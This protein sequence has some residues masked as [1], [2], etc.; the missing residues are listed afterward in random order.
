MSI[1][2]WSKKKPDLKSVL[3]T[4][5]IYIVFVILVSLL[6]IM[7]NGTFVSRANIVNVLRQISINGIIAIGMTFVIITGGIDLSVGAV[8]ALAG[9][10][11]SD[12]AHTDPKI[13]LIIPFLIAIGVGA[14]CGLNSGLIVSYVG[15]P[16]FVVTMGMMSIARGLTFLYTGGAPIKKLSDKF[17]AIGKGYYIGI[18]IP[19]YI[20]AIVLFIAATLLHKS[21][22]GRSLYAIG[23][24]EEAAYTSGIS[25]KS[26][27]TI[28]YIISGICAAI[29]GLI[30]AARTGA[31]AALAGDGYELNAIAAVVIGGTS[32]SGGKGTIM[33]TL[34]GALIIGSLSNGLDLM[35]V[36]SYIQTVVKG[37]III[38]AVCLDARA[39]SNAKR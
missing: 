34:I 16:P 39:M 3:R 20:L 31:A 10:I 24:N 2:G 28:A 38:A 26:Q 25:V 33:G 11:G 29:C 9:A 23:G 6:A 12:F 27:K 15:A 14:F 30:L 17:M 22:F 18:P 7:T 35:Y 36:S 21:K 4:Y 32:L 1:K 5:G 13:S 37:T 8:L 19:V